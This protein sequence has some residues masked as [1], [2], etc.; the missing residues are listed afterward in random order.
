MCCILDPIPVEWPGQSN[1][2]GIRG[3]LN[4]RLPHRTQTNCVSVSHQDF[5]HG[6]VLLAPQS[7]SEIRERRNKGSGQIGIHK[8]LINVLNSVQRVF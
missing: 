4:P 6:C 3:N 1:A 5:V 2:V 8:K 7:D